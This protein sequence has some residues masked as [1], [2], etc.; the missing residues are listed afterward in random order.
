MPVVTGD[1]IVKRRERIRRD[2]DGVICRGV[3]V[4]EVDHR[5]SEPRVLAELL[6]VDQPSEEQRRALEHLLPSRD[7]AV[8][9]LHSHEELGHRQIRLEQLF[10]VRAGTGGQPLHRLILARIID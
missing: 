7:H 2:R 6:V 4:D 10:D 9:D 8:E 3:A 5:E 1:Q